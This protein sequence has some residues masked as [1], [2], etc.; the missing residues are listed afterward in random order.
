M[1]E[2]LEYILI[3]AGILLFMGKLPLGLPKNAKIIL[4]IGLIVYGMSVGGWISMPSL[5]PASQTSLGMISLSD[6]TISAGLVNEV[7]TLDVISED[8]KHMDFYIV[9]ASAADTQYINW[10]LTL[11]RTENFGEDGIVDVVCDFDTKFMNAGSQYDLIQVDGNQLVTGNINSA[12][13]ATQT[14]ISKLVAFAEETT[15][16]DVEVTMPDATCV[17]GLGEPLMKQI[18]VDEV[19]QAER[20]GFV[21][22]DEKEGNK[23]KFW[24][25]HK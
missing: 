20:F 6:M 11:Y 23:L 12:G 7:A 25:T 17:S 21:K 16:V 22:L 13:T 24:Y 4:S 10:T 14:S 18:K 15:S 2:M 3:I 8:E 19:V 5:T 1:I 9:D